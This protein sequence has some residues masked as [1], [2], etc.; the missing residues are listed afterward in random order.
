MFFMLILPLTRLFSFS[1]SFFSLSSFWLSVYG[2]KFLSASLSSIRCCPPTVE[3]FVEG[4]LLLKLKI[5]WKKSLTY[6]NNKTLNTRRP[7]LFLNF[8]SGDMNMRQVGGP[9]RWT[10]ELLFHS[11]P[12]PPKHG[13]A[14]FCDIV[15]SIWTETLTASELWRAVL[16]VTVPKRLIQLFSG[17]TLQTPAFIIIWSHRC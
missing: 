3:D 1:V 14:P 16:W 13:S 4:M 12:L 5:L 15:I 6:G 7:A 9:T 10:R 17:T 11:F 2:P 8:H